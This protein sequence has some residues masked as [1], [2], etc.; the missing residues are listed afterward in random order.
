MNVLLLLGS[1]LRARA[2]ASVRKAKLDL[3]AILVPHH[4]SIENIHNTLGP[5][6]CEILS[7]SKTDVLSHILS[8]NPD[9]VFSIGWPYLFG[10]EIISGSYLLLNS[11]PSLLPKYRGINPWYYIIANGETE[12]GVTVH[13]IEEGIDSG[14][15]LYQESFPLTPF[16][17]YRSHRAKILALEPT[18]I[19]K[20]LKLVRSGKAVFQPQNETKATIYSKKRKP[21][22]S[23]IDPTKSLNELV[24]SIR[25]CDPEEF[26]AFFDYHGQDVYVHVTR[27][28]RPDKN[29]IEML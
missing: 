15:I 2:S 14:P 27:K 12:S 25:A 1:E 20:A 28:S 26:P 5:L 23:R 17:T 19:E 3:E 4:L 11:H 16:D 9:I 21:E 7:T 22:D 29:N 10:P 18:V 13:K 8:F 6:N 24:D